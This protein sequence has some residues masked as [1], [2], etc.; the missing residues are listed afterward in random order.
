MWH[1]LRRMSTFFF[2]GFVIAFV[3]YLF[4]YLSVG[5]VVWGVITGAAAGLALCVLVILLERRFPD[6]ETTVGK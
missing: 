3:I 5:E 2:I 4:F 1:F 6:R